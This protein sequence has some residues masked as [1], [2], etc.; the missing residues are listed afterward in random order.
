MNNLPTPLSRVESYLARAC[1]MNVIIPDSPESRLEQ[2]L[3]ILAGD[4]SVQM[5]TPHSLTEQWLA[6]V[7]GHTP[8]PLLEVIGAHYI[9]NQKVDTRY[10]AAAAGMPGVVLPAAPQNRKEQYWA[11][12]AGN[13]PTPPVG[14]LKYVTGTNIALTGVVSGI[15][16]LLH[17][18]G[19]T[20]QAESPAPSPDAPQNVLV[21]SGK[22]TVTI[23]G[24]GESAEYVIDLWGEE[25]DAGSVTARRYIDSGG[26]LRTSD[27]WNV[28]DYMP[29]QPGES[30]V[31]VLRTPGQN[32]RAAY[33]DQNKDLVN[34]FRQ[35]A[36]GTT[37][38]IP[39][40]V[41]YVRFSIFTGNS[42][43]PSDM[44]VFS[45][46]PDKPGVELC[47][48]DGYQDYIYKDGN[49]WY[50][51]KE[52]AHYVADGSV[53]WV[54]TAASATYRLEV[55]PPCRRSRGSLAGKKLVLSTHFQSIS[56]N[57]RNQGTPSCVLASQTNGSV[58]VRNTPFSSESAIN[59]FC[60]QTPVDFYYVAANATDTKITDARLVS[61]LNALN[62][63]V[64]PTPA[65]NISVSGNLAGA[66]EISYYGVSG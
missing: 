27:I 32:P 33:Y 57:D 45:F 17:V 40:G 51:H 38:T 24:G 46:G 35:V 8:S 6:Y 59:E 26:V 52:T 62:N 4:T 64:L 16:E 36:G 18:Y 39:E 5:P 21:V 58:L 20:V 12:I 23:S 43:A 60:A 66:I 53:G 54:S 28:S 50:L 25:F 48:I 44:G 61:Q 29:V 10:L 15:E 22:Q 7:L 56:Y 49:D 55:V 34:T 11:H 37:L 3:A 65:A 9:D 31:Y 14:V 1:G 2:F 42:T 30:Y 63:A 41:A 13:P 19:D 47:K